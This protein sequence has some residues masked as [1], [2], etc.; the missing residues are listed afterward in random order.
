MLYETVK[1]ETLFI[2]AIR[3]QKHKGALTDRKSIGK[4]LY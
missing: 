2:C 3:Q 4:T 1:K